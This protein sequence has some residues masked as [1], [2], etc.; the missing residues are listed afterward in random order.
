VVIGYTAIMEVKHPLRHQS[1][2]TT[3][4]DILLVKKTT[5]AVDWPMR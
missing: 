2:A 1:I 3:Q 5:G 4:R